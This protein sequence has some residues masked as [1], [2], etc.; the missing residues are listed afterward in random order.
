MK[1]DNSNTVFFQSRDPVIRKADDL[2]RHVN[3]LFPRISVTKAY[4]YNNYDNSMFSYWCSHTGDNLQKLRNITES[5]CKSKKS[6]FNKCSRFI[7]AMKKYFA[8]NCGESAFLARIAAELNGIKNAKLAGLYGYGENMDHSV[9][10]VNDKK[11]YIIDCWLG[12]AD[13]VP[14]AKQRYLSEFRQF[15]VDEDEQSEFEISSL[16]FD[17]KKSRN[18]FKS[19]RF[20]EKNITELKEKYPELIVK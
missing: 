15:I 11:P 13:Y 17:I 4:C 5:I 1:L 7:E 14:N 16:N 12:F 3:K 20:S 10:Y 9:V 18:A 8:G 6:N 2:A 19:M